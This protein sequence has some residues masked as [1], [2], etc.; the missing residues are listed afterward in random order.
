MADIGFNGS[1]PFHLQDCVRTA[2]IRADSYALLAS[3]SRHDIEGVWKY[4]PEYSAFGATSADK[5]SQV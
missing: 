1:G 4:F 3:L 5:E 2:W